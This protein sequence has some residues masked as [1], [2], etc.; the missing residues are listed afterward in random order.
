MLGH[1]LRGGTPTTFDRLLSLRFGAAAVR[2]LDEGQSGVMVA[3]DPPTVKYV[4]LEDATRRMKLVPLDC[5]T[6][7]TA[8]DLGICFGDDVRVERTTAAPA[9]ASA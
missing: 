4:R 1:L 5:D 6:I 2:A 3:L 8:R 7:Q 9:H